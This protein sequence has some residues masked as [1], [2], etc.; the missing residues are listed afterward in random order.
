MLILHNKKN[1]KL[2]M[3]HINDVKYPK[4]VDNET[5][6]VLINNKEIIIEED[7]TNLHRQLTS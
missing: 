7:Y 1:K 4:I 6:I 5:Y 3:L 2:L